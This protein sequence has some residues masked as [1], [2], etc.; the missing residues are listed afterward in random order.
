MSFNLSDVYSFGSG[1]QQD[2]SISD[3]ATEKLNSYARITGIDKN[4]ISI[5]KENSLEGDFEKFT[6]GVDILIHVSASLSATAKL[7]K[8]LVAKIILADND[9]LQL[10]K[11]FSQ[12]L[13]NEELDYYFVQAITFLNADCLSLKN[14]AVIMPPTYNPYFYRGGILCIKCWDSLNFSGGHISLTDC[15]IPTNRRNSLRPL[16]DSYTEKLQTPERLLLNSGEGACFIVARNI[17][18]DENSRIGDI[19]NQGRTGC[20]GSE[21]IT[22]ATNLGGSSI[23]LVANE[24]NNFSP[25]CISKYRKKDL[26]KGYAKCYIASNTEL[27]TDEK[28][29]AFDVIQDLGRIKKL[30]VIDFGRG[31]YSEVNPTF[32]LNNYALVDCNKNHLYLKK[33]TVKGLAAIQK[34]ATIIVQQFDNFYKAGFQIARILSVSGDDIFIDRDVDYK[35]AQIISVAEFSSLT[36]N[37]NY[38][39]TPAC[40]GIGGVFAV[41]CTDTLNLES[42][43]IDMTDKGYEQEFFGNSQMYDKLPMKDFG[44]IFILADNLVVNEQTKFLGNTFIVAKNH[45]LASKNFT[46]KAQNF[47]YTGE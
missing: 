18:F 31:I 15:G 37:K 34:G 17:Y 12:I 25:K 43:T 42:A 19:N 45:N 21:E 32:Q 16:L 47:I 4:L 23:I 7:G 40:Y 26:G 35:L 39:K 33:K 24:I 38:D 5:D 9:V 10:D 46:D 28:L 1:L 22:Q 27:K 29:F 2:I 3:G 13:T 30:G 44:A 6:A 36:I 41:A 14:N 11:D 8:Y 20:D